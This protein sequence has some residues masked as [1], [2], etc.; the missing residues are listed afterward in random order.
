[1]SLVEFYEYEDPEGGKFIQVR[2]MFIMLVQQTL[3]DIMQ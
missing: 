3:V 1:M 2:H